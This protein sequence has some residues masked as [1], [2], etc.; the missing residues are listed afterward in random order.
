PIRH[1]PRLRIK[2]RGI[3]AGGHVAVNN[4]KQFTRS[5]RRACA[6]DKADDASKH[7]CD[8]L[9][10]KECAV[11][12]GVMLVHCHTRDNASI[13]KASTHVPPDAVD[14]PVANGVDGI[15]AC[16]LCSACVCCCWACSIIPTS[17]LISRTD[18]G[19]PHISTQSTCQLHRSKVHPS[20]W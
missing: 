15:P 19:L 12:H 14:S 10:R 9:V 17:A 18:S 3:D 2:L 4:Q 8:E 16:M 1:E 20:R 5:E 13:F 7:Q 11:D 6:R